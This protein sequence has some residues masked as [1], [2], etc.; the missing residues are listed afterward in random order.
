MSKSQSEIDDRL[1][2]A[3]SLSTYE[4]QRRW[5][6]TRSAELKKRAQLVDLIIIG[7]G[8]LIAAV[9]SLVAE[10]YV[11]RVVS[12][13]GIIIAVL[14]GAQ[15]IYRSGETWPQYREAAETMKREM[16]LFAYGTGVY[17]CD[18]EPAKSH[19]KERLE[20]I[21]AGEQKTYF[22]AAAK[23]TKAGAAPAAPKT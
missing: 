15:R 16:R 5:Y 6:A 20:E 13:L 22:E 3:R 11:P 19:Y 14:Q 10:G 7:T 4:N 1:A 2:Y 23:Q 17:D 21:I 18:L 8:A 12:A 9:P